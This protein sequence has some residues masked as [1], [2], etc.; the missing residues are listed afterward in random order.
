MKGDRLMVIIKTLGLP[1]KLKFLDI[2]ARTLD[3][4]GWLLMLVQY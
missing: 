2:Y 1:S 4:I 3:S